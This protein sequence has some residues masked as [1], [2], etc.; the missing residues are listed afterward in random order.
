MNNYNW[1][2][3]TRQHIF[4]VLSS[5]QY[6]CGL[7]SLSE[8]K[9]ERLFFWSPQLGNSHLMTNSM[10]NQ[11]TITISNLKRKFSISFS[12][13]WSSIVETTLKLRHR[14]TMMNLEWFQSCVTKCQFSLQIKVQSFE[15]FQSLAFLSSSCKCS[16]SVQMLRS[17]FFV[18]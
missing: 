8:V 1:T 11:T 12:Y 4:C 10:P 14:N 6:I 5:D 2:G 17:I 9:N 16:E 3:Q 7:V 15:L 18:P 13:S